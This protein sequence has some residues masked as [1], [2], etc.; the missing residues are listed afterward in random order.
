MFTH[1]YMRDTSLSAQIR[2]TYVCVYTT[3]TYADSMQRYS[4]SP[5]YT[6]FLAKKAQKSTFLMCFCPFLLFLLYKMPLF[7]PLSRFIQK[8]KKQPALLQAVFAIL[9]PNAIR[10]ISHSRSPCGAG[11]VRSADTFAGRISFLRHS[12]TGRCS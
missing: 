12:P 1:S 4:F 9:L 11:G 6:N 7:A 10:A 8:H 2:A 5:K 3:H